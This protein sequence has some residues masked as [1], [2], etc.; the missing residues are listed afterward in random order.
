MD[1]GPDQ[2]VCATD[3]IFLGATLSGLATGGVWQLTVHLV[4][5]SPDTDPN[6]KFY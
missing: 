2:F 5:E 6:A 3:T 4:I 1:A